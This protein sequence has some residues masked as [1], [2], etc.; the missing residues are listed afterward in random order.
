[1]PLHQFNCTAKGDPAPEISWRHN[2][3]P[4]TRRLYDVT[5]S[6]PIPDPSGEGFLRTGSL[7]IYPLNEQSSGWVECVASITEDTTGGQV[8][9]SDVAGARLSVIGE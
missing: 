5:Q 9:S 6:M 2:G 3:Q 7:R 8:V 1:M 4:T